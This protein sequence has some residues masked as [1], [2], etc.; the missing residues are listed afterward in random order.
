MARVMTY[1]YTSGLQESTN[2]QQLNDLAS[3]FRESLLVLSKGPETRPIILVSHGLGGLIV[4]QVRLMIAS[5]CALL[6]LPGSR[7]P[8]RVQRQLR[9]DSVDSGARCRLLWGTTRR[10]EH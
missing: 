4:K 7:F 8:F 9:E 1:G 2:F 3:T 6:N 10:H 5:C